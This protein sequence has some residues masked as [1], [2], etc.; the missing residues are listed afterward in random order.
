MRSPGN[1]AQQPRRSPSPRPRVSMRE[2]IR[3]VLTFAIAN[4]FL[5]WV[6]AESRNPYMANSIR[7]EAWNICLALFLSFP[8]L[9]DRMDALFRW[10]GDDTPR[11]RR[12][13]NVLEDLM[14]LV[15][16]GLMFWSGLF[17]LLTLWHGKPRNWGSHDRITPIVILVVGTASMISWKIP[18]V[19]PPH[20]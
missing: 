6:I 2:L 5:A 15:I 12:K 3:L 10:L 14:A 8:F 7:Y 19:R 9:S 20:A 1:E 4:A 11:P 16:C 18:R 13:E 17:L